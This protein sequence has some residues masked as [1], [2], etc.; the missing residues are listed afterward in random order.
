MVDKI[1]MLLFLLSCSFAPPFG[2]NKNANVRSAISIDH[3]GLSDKHF[4]G[5]CVLPV[6]DVIRECSL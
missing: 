6:L 1:D 5:S 3:W 4:A 2:S